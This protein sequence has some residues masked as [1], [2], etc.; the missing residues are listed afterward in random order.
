[1]PKR[2]ASPTT[3]LTRAPAVEAE[4]QQPVVEPISAELKI[5]QQRKAAESYFQYVDIK[6]MNDAEKEM[7][8]ILRD[9]FS[10]AA[11]GPVPL[12]CTRRIELRT[13]GVHN[14]TDNWRRTIN[15]FNMGL[16][17]NIIRTSP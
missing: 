13:Y 3:T 14:Q 17:L 11:Q 9:A 7:I 4:A 15:A 1:M 12:H 10:Q 16:A 8:Q 6:P 2:K 5:E